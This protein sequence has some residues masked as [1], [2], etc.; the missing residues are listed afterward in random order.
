MV[1][2]SSYL[3]KWTFEPW[4]LLCFFFSFF[5]FVV[6]LNREYQVTQRVYVSTCQGHINMLNTWKLT[7]KFKERICASKPLVNVVKESSS[8]CSVERKLHFISHLWNGLWCSF[9]PEGSFPQFIHCISWML[10]HLRKLQKRCFLRGRSKVVF[11][12]EFQCV[13]C[14]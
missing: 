2:C 14:I 7:T 11:S 9:K 4:Q 6:H 13:I 8:R 5:Q 3:Y 10:S 12:I 1:F